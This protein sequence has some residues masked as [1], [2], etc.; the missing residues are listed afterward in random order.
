MSNN[1]KKKFEG[2]YR[3]VWDHQADIIRTRGIKGLFFWWLRILKAFI[4]YQ[5][6]N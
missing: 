5:G 4:N 2:V 3:L 6:E 1:A